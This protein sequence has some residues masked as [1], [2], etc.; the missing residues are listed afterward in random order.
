MACLSPEDRVAAFRDVLEERLDVLRR[1]CGRVQV[2]AGVAIAPVQGP[3]P[4]RGGVAQS[5][6]MLCDPIASTVPRRARLVDG[7]VP[8][9]D[10]ALDSHL[11]QH[12]R[13]GLLPAPPTDQE[14]VCFG[15]RHAPFS[16]GMSEVAMVRDAHRAT[17]DGRPLIEDFH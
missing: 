2:K 5:G 12:L 17:L 13:G 4:G 6:D 15:D 8:V 1:R 9:C 10:L 7:D 3:E 16:V 11:I 14:Q